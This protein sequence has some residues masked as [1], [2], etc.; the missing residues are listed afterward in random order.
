MMAVVGGGCV[1]SEIGGDGVEVTVDEED[2][3]EMVGGLE[4]EGKVEET[5]AIS[6]E[7]EVKGTVV[8]LVDTVDG[9]TV[10]TIVVIPMETRV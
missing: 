2:V 9:V 6:D 10:V 3:V 8:A 1:D 4:V 7:G 5:R